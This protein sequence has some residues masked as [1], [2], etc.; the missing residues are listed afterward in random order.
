MRRPPS[1]ALLPSYPV[2]GGIGLMASAV[3]AMTLTKRW[4][5]DAFTIGPNAFRSE[6][7]RLV[8]SLLPH[9]DPLHLIFNVYWLWVFGTLLEEQL[10]HSRL[11]LLV[12]L[13][14]ATSAAAEY[15]LFSGGIGL[16]GVGYGL[17]AMLWVLS[18]RDRRF[19]GAV[20]AATA[21]LFGIWFVFCIVATNLNVMAVANVAHGAGAVIGALVG[22]AMSARSSGRRALAGGG[23]A[24][25]IGVSFAGAT[26]LRPRVNLAHD[27]IASFQLGY[28]AIQ[29]RRYEDAVRSYRETLA[30]QPNDWKA[31]HNLGIACEGAGDAECALG[32]YRRSYE[33]DGSGERRQAYIGVALRVATNPST[34]PARAEQ[35]LRD[36]AA[37]D[38]DDGRAPRLLEW[39]SDGGAR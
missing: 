23:I 15:A 26:V 34:P 30:V 3:T 10:G 11:L 9:G 24:A 25:F 4:S 37:L 1:L 7:W 22:L 2:A 12:L 8:T 39:M 13:F 6:P 38:P 36:V 18:S 35:I 19:T 5:V 14:E 28:Q 20:D 27:G 17:F 16:S 21:R 32:A 29:E 33:L 31:W